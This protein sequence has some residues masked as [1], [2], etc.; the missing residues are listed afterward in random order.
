[1]SCRSC[2]V[3]AAELSLDKRLEKFGIVTEDLRRSGNVIAALMEAVVAALYLEHGVEAIREP[4]VAA[5]E[6]QIQEALT[7]PTDHKTALQEELAKTGRRVE[8]A[9]INV[10]GPAHERTFTC[11]VV[12]EGEQIGVGMGRTKKDAEQ[13]AARQA[14][15][16]LGFTPATA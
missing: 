13:E 7:V 4:V 1:M 12:L 8:Y 16:R 9:T 3:V 10:T 11:A 14:L 15:A 2:A 5:F 6:G